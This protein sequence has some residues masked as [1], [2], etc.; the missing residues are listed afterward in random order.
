MAEKI[1]FEDL[2][3]LALKLSRK[4]P[5]TAENIYVD[6][7]LTAAIKEIQLR[8]GFVLKGG[9]AIIK[10]WRTPYRFSYDLDFSLFEGKMPRKQYR[11]YQPQL[12]KL[13]LE[14]GFTIANPESDKHREGGRILILKLLDAPKFLRI[15]IK[16]SV[17]AIDSSP[18]SKPALKKFKPV[19]P[20]LQKYKLL[21]PGS[22]A[23]IT[24]VF[25]KVLAE[26]ELCAEKI[27]ALATRGAADEW[28]L[29]LRDVV[30]LHMMERSGILDRALSS[31]KCLQKKFGPIHGTSYWK[32]FMHFLSKPCDIKIH[33]EDLAIFFRPEIIGEKSATKVIEKVRSRLG[34]IFGGAN[35]E[36]GK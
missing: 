22:F 36:R 11:N 32:K 34:K 25:V 31:K 33:E 21:Y 29:L 6:L 10:A 30:D 27:R 7:L 5:F 9:T 12:E 24:G 3:E 23:R 18:C 20:I 35:L 13:L 4:P 16:I 8:F 2:H 17:S 26:E 14:L 28:S 15:P 19:V 1:N